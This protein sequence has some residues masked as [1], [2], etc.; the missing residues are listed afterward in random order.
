MSFSAFIIVNPAPVPVVPPV[1]GKVKP[2]PPVP[3]LFTL[4]L[5]QTQTS[6]GPNV[7]TSLG[8]RVPHHAQGKDFL[9]IGAVAPPPAPIKCTLAYAQPDQINSTKVFVSATKKPIAKDPTTFKVKGSSTDC[10]PLLD[11]FLQPTTAYSAVP[12]PA[13]HKSL[14]IK[15]IK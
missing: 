13:G 9:M 14:F 1:A 12:A 4:L 5:L 11:T 10:Q 15:V 7:K 6:A 2:P 8:S 3:I